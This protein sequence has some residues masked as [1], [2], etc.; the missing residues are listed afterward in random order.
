MEREK[1]LQGV[2]AKV[3]V[4]PEG[5]THT[6]E[7]GPESV[8]V[9]SI[10]DEVFVGGVLSEADVL[11]KA[12]THTQTHPHPHTQAVVGGD[13][14]DSTAST[15]TS[16]SS[17]ST[18]GTASIH[19]CSHLPILFHFCFL[20]SLCVF[21]VLPFTPFPPLLY[22][23]FSCATSTSFHYGLPPFSPHTRATSP[24]LFSFATYFFPPVLPLL[25]TLRFAS[26][27][28]PFPQEGPWLQA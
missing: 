21:P 17:S 4:L 18:T 25:L 27:Q 15:T 2:M 12:A 6:H 28:P 14:V 13:V 19:G 20:S 8:M 16:S 9:L 11:A 26:F 1:V 10:N 22:P 3:P 5:H 7:S 24:P 23:S